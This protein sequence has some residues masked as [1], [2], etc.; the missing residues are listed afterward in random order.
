[1]FYMTNIFSTIRETRHF[2]FS[3]HYKGTAKKILNQ[4]HHAKINK[5]NKKAK[6]YEQL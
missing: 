5:R 1:M 3:N 6:K 2:F 4:T